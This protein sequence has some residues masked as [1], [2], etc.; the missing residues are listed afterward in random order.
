MPTQQEL[1]RLQQAVNVVEDVANGPATGTDSEVA[2]LSGPIK[3]VARVVSELAAT[4]ID[5]ATP[6]DLGG[7]RKHRSN[8]R[9]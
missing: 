5:V 3:T 1:E 7:R 2:T 8:S 4:T 9:R 6:A